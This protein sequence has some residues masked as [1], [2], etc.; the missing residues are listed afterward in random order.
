MTL[1]NRGDL[2]IELDQRKHNAFPIGTPDVT[3]L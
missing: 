2:R 3:D 1:S